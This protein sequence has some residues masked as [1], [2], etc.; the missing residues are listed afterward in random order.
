[1]HWKFK[2]RRSGRKVHLGKYVNSHEVGSWEMQALKK[3]KT[4]WNCKSRWGKKLQKEQLDGLHVRSQR[5]GLQR[6]RCERLDQER[7]VPSCQKWNCRVFHPILKVCRWPLRNQPVQPSLCTL[8][9]C[10]AASLWAKTQ[11]SESNCPGKR[12]H[13]HQAQINFCHAEFSLESSS[14]GLFSHSTTELWSVWETHLFVLKISSYHTSPWSL[15][16]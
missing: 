15:S 13:T 7:E 11:C 10:T 6:S 12:K 2:M 8:L 3:K 9:T 5:S 4:L 14:S 1:M 16:V